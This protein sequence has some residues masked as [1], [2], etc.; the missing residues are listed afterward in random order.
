MFLDTKFFDKDNKLHAAVRQVLLDVANDVLTDLK[1]KAFFTPV[2]II[3]TGSMTGLNWDDESDLDVHIG[4]DFTKFPADEVSL[5]KN[6]LAYYARVFNSNKYTLKGRNIELYFQD[7]N[8]KHESPGIYNLQQDFWIKTPDQTVAHFNS[9]VKEAA[10]KYLSEVSVLIFEWE[11][12]SRNREDIKKFLDKV[13][14]YMK[15]VV[16]MRKQSLLNDGMSG[17]GNQVFR[18]L[19]RNGVLP[20]LSDLRKEAQDAYYDVYES[21]RD[22]MSKAKELLKMLEVSPPGWS[23][24]VKAMKKNKDIDNPFALAWFL[25]KKGAKPR[26]KPESEVIT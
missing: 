4:V 19:R 24:T 14:A 16:E 11:E 20:K 2:F 3:L 6:M 10:G 13:N 15:Q 7:S 26:Y 21:R 8:E 25:K 1:D 12:V 18:E 23:G 9:R 22:N 5:Y 17:F